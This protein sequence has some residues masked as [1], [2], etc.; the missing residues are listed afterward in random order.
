MNGM[1]YYKPGHEPSWRK[2]LGQWLL[3]GTVFAAAAAWAGFEGKITWT[4]AGWWIAAS[5]F[6]SFPLALAINFFDGSGDLGAD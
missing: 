6:V 3:I 4:A 5:P 1:S 2:L